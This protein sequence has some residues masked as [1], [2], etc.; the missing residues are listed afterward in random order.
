MK[1]MR[2]I[3][4][5]ILSAMIFTICISVEL[6]SVDGS[7]TYV[8]S[9]EDD[10][11]SYCALADGSIKIRA[12]DGAVF[13]DNMSI[14]SALDSQN[15]TAIDDRAFV[16]QQDLTAVTIPDSVTQIGNSAFSNCHQLSKV[17]I[18]G[19]ITNIGY[20]PFYDTPFE[21]TLQKRGDFI[22]LNKDILY[23]YTGSAETIIV[24]DG[25]RVISANLFTGFESVREFKINYV[26]IPDSVEYICTGAF[27]GC[28]N[29]ISVIMGSGIKS[30]GENAFTA[31]SMY[32][33]GYYE[34]AAQTYAA[35]AGFTFQPIIEYGKQSDTVYADFSDGFRQFYFTDE[36]EF[37]REG[38]FVYRRNYNGEKIEITDWQYSAK[39]SDLSPADG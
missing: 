10:R 24:P 21:D 25:I 33:R 35:D 16:G 34:T 23:G 9:T 5:Y 4:A 2:N 27:Y 36:T 13:E 31:E 28:D 3:A 29:I 18:Q 17:E 22:I 15:V 19:K 7:E 39:L 32:I 37:S 8:V 11:F 14:P 26:S 20:Y 12:T 6:M 38:V 1:K 30:I